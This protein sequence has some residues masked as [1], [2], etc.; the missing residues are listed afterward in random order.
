MRLFRRVRSAT[1]LA[2]SVETERRWR[3]SGSG[4][5]TRGRKMRHRC[6]GPARLSTLRCVDRKEERTQMGEERV[7]AG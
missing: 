1:R 3:A 7:N 4:C 2:R 5:Q 6:R